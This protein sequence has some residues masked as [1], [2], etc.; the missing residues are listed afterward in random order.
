MLVWEVYHL[1]KSLDARRR[2]L[3]AQRLG[4]VASPKALEPLIDSLEDPSSEVRRESAIAL[5]KIGD[6][7]AIVPLLSIRE[8]GEVAIEARKAARNIGENNSSQLEGALLHPD[9]N[10]RT[11]AAAVLQLMEW[12]PSNKTQQAIL[13]VVTQNWEE[14]EEM[15]EAAQLPLKEWLADETTPELL[16]TPAAV[17]FAKLDP[18]QGMSCLLHLAGNLA[19]AGEA[20]EALEKVLEEHTQEMTTDNLQFAATLSAKHV[21]Y[22]EVKTASYDGPFTGASQVPE[23]TEPIDCSRIQQLA[24]D[25]LERRGEKV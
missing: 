3:S 8:I 22:R 24:K 11:K 19:V 6:S 4:E 2:A 1:R 13:A 23:G 21:V 17:V 5:G 16:K 10:V 12:E 14:V 20:V 15:G 7:R 9:N 25:E 18:V